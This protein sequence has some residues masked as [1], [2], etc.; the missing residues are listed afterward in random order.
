MAH[1]VIA[2]E[3][4]NGQ[5]ELRDIGVV[6]DAHLKAMSEVALKQGF[7]LMFEF[8]SQP[9][10]VEV[11]RRAEAMDDGISKMDNMARLWVL[12]VPPEPEDP[13]VN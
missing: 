8:D 2:R 13:Q 12:K 11:V 9:D 3:F 4:D 7:D 5:L 1:V 6:E 10:M